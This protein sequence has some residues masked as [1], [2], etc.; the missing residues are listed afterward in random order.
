MARYAVRV[1]EILK[2]TV[3]VEADSFEEAVDKAEMAYDCGEIEVG[4]DDFYEKQIG[5]SEYFGEAPVS[6]EESKYYPQIE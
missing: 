3:M 6:E 5:V 4:F 1:T 2:K